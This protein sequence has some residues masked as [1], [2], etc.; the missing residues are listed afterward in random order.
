MTEDLV[1]YMKAAI[2]YGGNFLVDDPVWAEDFAPDG[3]LLELGE[4]IRR[5]R[6]A[7]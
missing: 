4:T 2:S 5:K 3:K 7:K 6:Y 1:R